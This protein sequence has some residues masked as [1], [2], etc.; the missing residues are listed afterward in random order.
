M[1]AS[2]YEKRN[3][4]GD[5]A[6]S[7]LYRTCRFLERIIRHGSSAPR[8]FDVSGE[9][10]DEEPIKLATHRRNDSPFETQNA[11]LRAADVWKLQNGRI[12][13]AAWKSR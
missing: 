13:P 10:D 6:E 7:R 2:I 8:L 5:A 9:R 3:G 4:S 1:V 12:N 11:S